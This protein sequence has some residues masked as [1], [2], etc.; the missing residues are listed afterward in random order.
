MSELG[1]LFGEDLFVHTKGCEFLEGQ[2]F[3]VIDI[4]RVVEH[5]NHRLEFESV[6]FDVPE[7]RQKLVVV[8]LFVPVQVRGLKCMDDKVLCPIG[9]DTVLPDHTEH[10]DVGINDPGLIFLVLLLDVFEL[11][12]Y[13]PQFLLAHFIF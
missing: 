13:V 8:D 5:L 2:A 7:K 6:G 1:Y 11:V 10:E 12:L 4:R 9:D 3:I